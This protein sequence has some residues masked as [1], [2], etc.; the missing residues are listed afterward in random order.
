[1]TY[2]AFA[3]SR[4]L[5]ARLVERSKMLLSC[6]AGNTVEDVAEQLDVARQTVSRWLGRYVERGLEGIEKDAALRPAAADPAY[7]SG[8]DC[9]QDHTGDASS[10]YSLEHAHPG[11]GDRGQRFDNWPHLAR[12]WFEAAFG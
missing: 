2:S 9:G 11:S 10:R 7:A 1:M 5:P 4:T 12:T 6:A 3:H 8:R